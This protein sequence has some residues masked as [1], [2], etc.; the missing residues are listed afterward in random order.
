MI[1]GEKQ[2]T[3][4]FKGGRRSGW[5]RCVFIMTHSTVCKKVNQLVSDRVVSVVVSERRTRRPAAGANELS[6]IPENRRRAR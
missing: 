1:I 3:A 4:E 5:S 2:R 6:R